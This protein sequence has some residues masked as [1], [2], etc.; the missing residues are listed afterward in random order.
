[1]HVGFTHPTIA[2]LAIVVSLAF[3]AFQLKAETTRDLIDIMPV[4]TGTVIGITEEGEM[5]VAG[6]NLSN[7]PKEEFVFRQW[8]LE[9]SPRNMELL[10]FGRFV[11]CEIYYASEQR[12]VGDCLVKVAR[13]DDPPPVAHYMSVYAHQSAVALDA[14]DFPLGK[15]GC[16]D[17]DEAN[18]PHLRF[19]FRQFVRCPEM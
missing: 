16:T 5:I 18:L 3:S 12:L 8:A 19:Q 6:T 9:I 17:E 7:D 4:G 14:A 15:T 1:V 2:I 10:S 11:T 13:S